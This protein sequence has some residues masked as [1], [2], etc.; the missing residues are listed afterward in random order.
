MYHVKHNALQRRQSEGDGV[1]NKRRPDCLLTS[2]LRRRSKKRSKFR[3]TGP[4]EGNPRVTGWFP[5]QRASNAENISYLVRSYWAICDT[6]SRA[7]TTPA[8]IIVAHISN[9]TKWY[10]KFFILLKYMTGTWKYG[11]DLL[12][13]SGIYIFLARRRKLR[14]V[15]YRFRICP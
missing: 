8:K 4:C 5:S 15:Q 13:I 10:V 14:T 3:A 1:S 2:L 12:E 11:R 6:N 7:I 9:I